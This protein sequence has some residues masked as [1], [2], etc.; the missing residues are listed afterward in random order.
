MKPTLTN[1][2]SAVILQ[3]LR[4]ATPVTAIGRTA[5][6]NYKTFLVNN[7]MSAIA[8][9]NSIISLQTT[10]RDAGLEHLVNVLKGIMP[11]SKRRVAVAYE[12][13]QQTRPGLLAGATPEMYTALESLYDLDAVQIIKSINDGALDAFKTNPTIAQLISWANAAVKV[14]PE[15]TATYGQVGEVDSTLVPVLNLAS[16]GDNM[17]VSIDGKVYLQGSRGSLQYLPEAA[18]YDAMNDDVRL[19]VKAVNQMIPSKTEPNVLMLRP[20]LLE[21]AEKNLGVNSF[22]IDLLGNM[23][24]FVRLNGEAMSASKA[25]AL[26]SQNK[27]AMIANIL[28]GDNAKEILSVLINIMSVFERYRDSIAGSA[29][30]NKFSTA[31]TDI[32]VVTKDGFVSLIQVV[33]GNVVSTKAFPTMFDAIRSD[34]LVAA[35]AFNSAVSAIFAD[36]LKKDNER[37]SV[38]QQIVQDMAREKA[39]YESLL[40][41]INT[42]LNELEQVVDVNPDKVK[43]LNELKDK[44]EANV[45]KLDEQMA[46]LAK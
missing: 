7:A 42:E 39:E 2:K 26:L 32:Y 5:V 24:N 35:P 18:A 8:L 22:K 23:D 12:L 45:A 31:D 44:A 6:E 29:Y 25:E 11:E 43:A 15:Q 4:R 40:Q 14:A 13:L 46:D 34:M 9:E 28:L 38:K 19:L 30:A 33:A 17:L 21:V 20:E 3:A 37:L 16:T 27:D 41:R 1:I 36:Q 10:H